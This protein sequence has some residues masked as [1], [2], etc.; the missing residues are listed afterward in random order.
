M[1]IFEPIQLAWED[2]E[3]EVP[4]DRVMGAIQRIEDV[5]TLQEL[6][7]YG[8]RGVA[9]Q[10][11]VAAAYAAVLRYAGCPVSDDQVYLGMFGSGATQQAMVNSINGLLTMMIPPSLRS[12]KTKAPP[13]G[14]G[15]AP[16]RP[17]RGR[18]SSRRRSKRRSG[19]VG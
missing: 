5:V 6:L 13:E 7:A 12:G 16:A 1:S 3:Y 17:G 4:S 8:E 15:S 10:A 14:N 19:R 9:P 2:R 11:K 18:R